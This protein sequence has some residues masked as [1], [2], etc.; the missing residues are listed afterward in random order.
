MYDVTK[1]DTFASVKRW[2]N[3]IERNCDRVNTVLVGNK[4]D[5]PDHQVPFEEA[6]KLADE[7]SIPIFEA[8][9]KTGQNVDEA[10]L[11]ITRMALKVKKEGGTNPDAKTP[12]ETIRL[13]SQGPAKRGACCA[14]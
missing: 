13:A 5:V 2:L 8:S 11:T 1:E 12:K 6:K 3:E 4:C 9:A 14:K 7:L 10:F